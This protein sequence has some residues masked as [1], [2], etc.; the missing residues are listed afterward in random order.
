MAP[1]GAPH[2]LHVLQLGGC[3]ALKTADGEFEQ[4]TFVAV[5]PY[6]PLREL[7]AEAA[8]LVLDNADHAVDA[9]QRALFVL[10]VVWRRH[11]K[12]VCDFGPLVLV[13]SVPVWDGLSWWKSH[14]E[15][16]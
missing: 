12:A 13:L 7:T 16:N 6:Q 4:E 2:D 1:D 5:L 3:T 11:I 15:G 10:Q 8:E 14:N 9:R